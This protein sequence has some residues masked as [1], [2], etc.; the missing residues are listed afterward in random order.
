MATSM[1][2]EK[3]LE[4]IRGLE[5]TER[6]RLIARQVIK[7]ACARLEFLHNVG[8]G[9]L[10]LDRRAGTLRRRKPTDS[11]CNPDWLG[12]VGVV[13]AGRAQHRTPPRITGNSWIP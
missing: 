2:C 3:A 7:E 4:F 9:Y 6:E 8:L 12:L 10:T 13:C 11:A 5:L 1:S